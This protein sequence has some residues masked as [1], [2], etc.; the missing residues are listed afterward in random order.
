MAENINLRKEYFLPLTDKKLWDEANFSLCFL[1]DRHQ[2]KIAPLKKIARSVF[3][4]YLEIFPI[5][6]ELCLNTC[7][8]CPDPCCL[9]AKVWFDLKD[10]L[11][12]HLN[13]LPLPER[14]LL[15]SYRST[16]RYLGPR[17][18]VLKREVRPFICTLYICPPQMARLRK[19]EISYKKFSEEIIKI[20]AGR[21]TIESLFIEITTWLDQILSR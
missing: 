17:G 8:F 6:D 10:M 21:N 3:M 13:Q 19:E 14:Q 12:L 2:K 4:S 20:K 18:C 16:C 1:L 7:C 15:K 11:F 9:N 5:L